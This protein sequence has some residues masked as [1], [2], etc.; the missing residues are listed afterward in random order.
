MA[1]RPRYKS[2][3]VKGIRSTETGIV[4]EFNPGEAEFLREAPAKIHK[5]T[6]P[7]RYAEDDK[8]DV[9][10]RQLLD[11]EL[12]AH[13]LARVLEF[14]KMLS[15]VQDDR[16]E[17]THQQAET[18]LGILTDLRLGL[19]EVIGIKDESWEREI[20]PTNPPSED[21]ALYFYF[22]A[23]QSTLLDRGFG[24]SESDLI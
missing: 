23:L 20:D 24:V 1:C 9:E 2:T 5:P 17:L 7:A 6:K 11:A 4:L 19:A 14:Q 16:L 8:V 13:R 18:W 12:R 15:G 10:L 22:T 3:D 21:V